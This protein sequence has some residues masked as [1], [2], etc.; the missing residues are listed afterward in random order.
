MD[1]RMDVGVLQIV[2]WSYIHGLHE[3]HELY[4][5][6]SVSYAFVSAA[7]FDDNITPLDK[8]H[9]S[10]SRILIKFVTSIQVSVRNKARTPGCRKDQTCCTSSGILGPEMK[11]KDVWWIVLGMTYVIVLAGPS[12]ISWDIALYF[13]SPWTRRCELTR[14]SFSYHLFLFIQVV[15]SCCFMSGI[16]GGI[17]RSVRRMASTNVAGMYSMAFVTVPDMD[18]GRKLAQ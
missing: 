18:V 5:L 14:L 8:L 3:F 10:R 17:C 12:N 9:L 6:D 1:C 2:Y 16:F 7:S 13:G 4:C 11:F 15:I